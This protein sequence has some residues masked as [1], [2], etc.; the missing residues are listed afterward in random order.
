MINI[1]KIANNAKDFPQVKPLDRKIIAAAVLLGLDNQTA[2][3]LYHPE[4][5]NGSGKMNEAG[6]TGSANFWSRNQS[7]DY[8][9]AYERTV[10]SFFGKEASVST[11][12]TDKEK[13]FLKSQFTDKVYRALGDAEGIEQLKDAADLGK[14]V[15]I[16]KEDETKQESP[17]R[18]LPQRCDNCSYKKF[19]D[20]AI[21]N[22]DILE[23]KDNQ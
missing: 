20:E 18:Y 8:R 17:R 3:Q 13:E 19:I 5:L 2:Y 14:D 6:K 9:D 1:P 11:E 10:L 4:Y 15:K 23:I 12:L 16:F 21:K 7:R 22:G